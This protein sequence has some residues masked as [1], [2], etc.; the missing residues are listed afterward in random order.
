MKRQYS[1]GLVGVGLLVFSVLMNADR[2]QPFP[3]N[4]APPAVQDVAD[5]FSYSACNCTPLSNG[6]FGNIS[7][8]PDG[9]VWDVTTGA[10]RWN[11]AGGNGGQ[12]ICPV[13]YDFRF[14]SSSP[15]PI[16][17]RVDVIDNHTGDEVRVDVFGQTATGDPGARLGSANTANPETGRRELVVT[18][19]TPAT[20]IRYMWLLVDVPPRTG[21]RESG[22]IGYRVNRIGF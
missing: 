12:L 16:E 11:E 8:D 22:V 3:A 5:E 7:G 1:L 10:W 6:Q 17:F 20:D 19:P 21:E 4:A 14:T 2:V 15:G 18:V 9:F 13:P